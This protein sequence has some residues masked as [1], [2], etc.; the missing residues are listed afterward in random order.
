[1]K[2]YGKSK[3]TAKQPQSKDDPSSPLFFFLI[4]QDAGFLAAVAIR[5]FIY[6]GLENL[7]VDSGILGFLYSP[8]L[9]KAN[10]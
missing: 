9:G 8:R 7:I 1:M 2:G 3:T 5:D 6:L 10:Y 4:G